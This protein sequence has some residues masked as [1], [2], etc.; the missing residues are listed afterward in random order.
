MIELFGQEK[1]NIIYICDSLIKDSFNS[2][3]DECEIMSSD[4]IL[5]FNEIN[6]KK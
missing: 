4:L 1:Q 6:F 2:L 3:D 5:F